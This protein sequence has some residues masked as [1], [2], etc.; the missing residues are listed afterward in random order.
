M[1]GLFNNITDIF[2]NSI[3]D[4]TN[5]YVLVHSNELYKLLIN[6]YKDKTYGIW[7]YNYPVL[8]QLFTEK[9]LNYKNY[10]PVGHVYLNNG[11]FKLSN[12]LFAN[13]QYSPTTQKFR[14]IATL[15]KGSLWEP[16]ID[17]DKYGA[18]GLVYSND[19]SAPKSEIALVRRDM[20]HVNETNSKYVVPFKGVFNLVNH[21]NVGRVK[22][23]TNKL[24]KSSKIFRMFNRGGKYLTEVDGSPKMKDRMDQQN[25]AVSYNAQGELIVGGKCLKGKDYE[26]SLET[27]NG[28]RE[29]RWLH[30]DNEYTTLDDDSCLTSN[31]ENISLKP[32]DDSDDDK[33]WYVENQESDDSNLYVARSDT[34]NKYKGKSV[35]LVEA[36]NPW[37]A[38]KDMSVIQ[39]VINTYTEPQNDLD[40]GFADFK[41]NFNIDARRKDLGYGSSYAS[42]QGEKCIE[43]FDESE[44]RNVIFLLCIIL[45]FLILYKIKW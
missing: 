28:S 30:K 5:P 38:N 25:Q 31:D 21:T 22:L 42:R 15:S 45:A 36:E 7:D 40:Y 24:Y 8:K 12:I 37:Y 32:C 9:N 43:G 10:V 1:E 18:L 19:I 26:I 29:Q 11:D 34:N 39:N 33:T 35:V 44:N 27:C 2:G 4:D 14:F 20:T 3:V 13:R 41:S 17:N 23:L 16:V 6:V